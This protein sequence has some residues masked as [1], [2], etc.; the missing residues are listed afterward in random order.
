MC[1]CV[2]VRAKVSGLDVGLD[3]G[4]ESANVGV[5]ARESGLGTALSPGY[6]TDH[7]T[8]GVVAD[9]AAGV[10]LAGI[11]TTIRHTSAEH[12]S[13]DFFTGASVGVT[14]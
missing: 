6:D 7:G 13:G 14:Q 3:E 9:R 2:R 4:T 11:E 5:D 10:T 1:V 12:D 8:G